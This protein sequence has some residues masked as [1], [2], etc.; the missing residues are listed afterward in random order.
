MLQELKS[1]LWRKYS[2]TSIFPFSQGAQAGSPDLTSRPEEP[3]RFGQVMTQFRLVFQS[4]GSTLLFLVSGSD[5]SS[6]KNKRFRIQTQSLEKRTHYFTYYYRIYLAVNVF[7]KIR[8]P[9]FF[10]YSL[11]EVTISLH[12][13]FNCIN[14]KVFIVTKNWFIKNIYHFFIWIFFYLILVRCFLTLHIWKFNNLALIS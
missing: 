14:F 12:F 6:L 8:I 2:L 5:T 11:I 7:L 1:Q 3:W 4:R 10:K 13:F 9:S